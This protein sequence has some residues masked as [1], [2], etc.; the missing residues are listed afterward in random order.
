[1]IT[2][3]KGTSAIFAVTNFSDASAPDREGELEY[4][5]GIAMAEAAAATPTLEHYIWST[6]PSAEVATGGKIFVPH[7]DYKARVDDYIK[8]KIPHLAKKTTFLWMGF[9]ATNL[10]Y[11]PPFKPT[12]MASAIWERACIS[13]PLC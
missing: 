5:Q 4:K 11:F 6:L 3:A 12:Y 2:V 8:K 9:Y 7:A 1:M 10:A 13:S